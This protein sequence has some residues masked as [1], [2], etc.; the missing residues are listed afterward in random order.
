MVDYYGMTFAISALLIIIHFALIALSYMF[1]KLLSLNFLENY[2]K[3]E[4]NQ[5]FF[6]LLIL[7]SIFVG[8]IAINNLFCISL[9]STGFTSMGT[10]APSGFSFNDIQGTLHLNVARSKLA[11]FYND[12]RVLAKGALKAYDW[13]EFFNNLSGGSALFSSAIPGLAFSGVHRM[14]YGEI[15]TI[16]SGVLIFLKFQELFLVINAV[17]FFPPF[18]YFG[19]ILRI[20]PFTRKLGG[21]LLSITL[22]LFFVL[23]YLY[24]ASWIIMEATPS[25]GTKYI[26][27][28][29]STISLIGLS[30]VM[31]ETDSP[32]EQFD[33][34]EYVKNK[35]FD[36]EKKFQQRSTNNTMSH[37]IEGFANETERI[38]AEGKEQMGELNANQLKSE[39]SKNL[40]GDAKDFLT[41]VND[42]KNNSFV[43]IAARVVLSTIFLTIFALVGTISAIKEIS[44]IF[45]GDVEI[46]GLTRLI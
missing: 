45:G 34:S 10:C 39:S 8:I 9:A 4:L 33:V 6:S 24:I 22:S 14:I 29:S 12:V 44:K 43:E 27:D 17:Y 36:E 5:A 18:L 11:L 15:F 25:F 1:S 38:E 30:N 19:L 40:Y 26:I 7:G 3:H 28:T 37:V 13:M 42:R 20:L 16:L 23:P 31:G 21:L 2:A 46:A 35:M 41:A 32:K